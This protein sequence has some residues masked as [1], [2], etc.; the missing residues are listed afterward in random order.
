MCS[1]KQLD[2][3]RSAT[4]SWTSARFFWL[5]WP[6]FLVDERASSQWPSYLTGR[7]AAGSLPSQPPSLHSQEYQGTDHGAD[8]HTG[9]NDIRQMH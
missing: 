3:A 5:G 2:K 7:I 1:M 9:K 6:R 4:T 8:H